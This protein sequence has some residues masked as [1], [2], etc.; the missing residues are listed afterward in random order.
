MTEAPKPSTEQRHF[1]EAVDAVA[2][3]I[4]PQWFELPPED[5]RELF[6]PVH[7]ELV[8]KARGWARL[9]ILR[10]M[11][12]ALDAPGKLAA[13]EL[14]IAKAEIER[15][16]QEQK[17][18]PVQGFSAGI[19]WDMHLRAYDVYCK[20]YGRQR[21]L[22]E[23]NCRGGFGTGE[24][25]RFIPGWRDELSERIKLQIRAKM[26]EAKGAA[27]EADKARMDWLEQHD[28]SVAI[29]L[30][31]GSRALFTATSDEEE[32]TTDLRARIDAALGAKP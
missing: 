6:G 24:L 3:E 27:L 19:P 26:A 22:I 25:D 28:V 2:R 5:L 1:D 9:G 11:T 13:E 14:V 30:R 20:K 21:A 10:G 32:T 12:L 16:T 29:P 17:R 18:A 23:G 7:E 15:L 8:A 4:A 31:W